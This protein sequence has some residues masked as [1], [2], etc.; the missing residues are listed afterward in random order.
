MIPSPQPA[1]ERKPW[2]ETV[3]EWTASISSLSRA[4]FPAE[5]L[6]E[7]LPENAG[8]IVREI[9]LRRFRPFPSGRNAAWALELPYLP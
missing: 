6:D 1:Q 4:L 8:E 5:W 7:G 9:M 2:R 3:H